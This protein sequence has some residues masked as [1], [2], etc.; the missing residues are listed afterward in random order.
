MTPQ[1]AEPVEPEPDTP[2]PSETEIQLASDLDKA[3]TALDEMREDRNA[4]RTAK[5]DDSE[6][7]AISQCTKAL[8][9]F[10]SRS[11]SSGYSSNAGT[12]YATDTGRIGRVLRYLAERYSVD[13]TPNVQVLCPHQ[14]QP[15]ELARSLEAAGWRKDAYR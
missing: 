9:A 15:D 14:D 12:L 1:A 10:V 13:L 8:D 7:E 11:T 3:Q 2:E 6:A 5:V 4:W